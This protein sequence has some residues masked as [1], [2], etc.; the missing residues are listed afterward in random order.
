MSGYRPIEMPEDPAVL[1]YLAGLFDADG[2]VRVNAQFTSRQANWCH[3]VRV[4]ITNT[5]I[6]VMK[7]L[8]E[9]V[10][11]KVRTR[12][13]KE[14]PKWKPRHDWTLRGRN[15]E[16]FLEAVLPYLVIKGNR[17]Q[18]ALELGSTKQQGR[19]L[20]DELV[21]KREALSD[22]MHDLNRRGIEQEG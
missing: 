21:R 17:A 5:D 15:A 2:C 1:G 14:Q 11:G 10:G 20:T 9:H 19:P 12:A 8:V 22:K 6:V 3:T 4:I 13:S 7:W 18:V 16:R